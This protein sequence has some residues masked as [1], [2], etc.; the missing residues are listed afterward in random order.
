MLNTIINTSLLL[1][2]TVKLT[3]FFILFF[4]CQWFYQ[5]LKSRLWVWWHRWR[6]VFSHQTVSSSV[7]PWTVAHQGFL[8]FTVSWSLLR[9]MFIE[10][11]MPSNRLN[12]LSPLLLMP[13]VFPSIRVFPVSFFTSGSQSIGASALVLPMNT[14]GWLM[15]SVLVTN[16]GYNIP[17]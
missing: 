8:S 12:S 3:R 7:T 2:N 16:N 17:W 13:S 14:Q 10:S 4:S 5:G 1:D 9:L 11:V 6:A 15:K